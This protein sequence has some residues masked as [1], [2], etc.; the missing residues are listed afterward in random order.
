MWPTTPAL[1]RDLAAVVA[2]LRRSTVAVLPAARARGGP[3][4]AAATIGAGIVWS[5]DGHV[6]TNAHVARADVVRVALADG[7][8]APGRV[9]ARDAR[10]DLALLQVEHD[11]LEPALP[12]RPAEARS[13]EVVIAHGHP[14]GVRD[15][16]A[17]GILHAGPATGARRPGRVGTLPAGA[18]PAAVLLQADIRLAPGNS[19]GPLAD[20]HGRVLGVNTLIANGMGVAVSID[21]VRHLEAMVAPRPRLG[22]TLRPVAVREGGAAAPPRTASL[23]LAVEPDG[24][25]ARGGLRP[26][27]VVLGTTAAA[28]DGPEALLDALRAAGGG[29]TL[30]LVIGRDGRRLTL[31]LRLPAATAPRRAA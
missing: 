12:G 20:V 25:A 24:A 17:I 6:V 19:G 7:R 27:D 22:V 3:G 2:R 11:D 29:G 30:P 18:L 16:S 5:A 13:G 9:V 26:G 23:V 8:Q 31:D 1:E 21:E 4:G 15:A 28:L 10:R 14:L